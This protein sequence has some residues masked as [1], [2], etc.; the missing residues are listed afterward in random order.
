M[1]GELA[2]YL[3]DRIRQ[4]GALIPLGFSWTFAV[5]VD[6][7][8]AAILVVAMLQRPPADLGICLL[9]IFLAVIPDVWF[10]FSSTKF[11]PAVMW[12]FAMITTALLLDAEDEVARTAWRAAAGLVPPEEAGALAEL[13]LSLPCT[14]HE[15]GRA[16]RKRVMADRAHPD[17]G[18][19]EE[20]FRELMRLRS[21]AMAH[22]EASSSPARPAA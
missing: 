3:G 15:L 7:T 19:S 9:A 1:L 2:T 18:G 17:Q 22:V 14:A 6:V 11:H 20:E 13:G 5:V 10:F 21:L 12:V 8:M 4:R 16:F